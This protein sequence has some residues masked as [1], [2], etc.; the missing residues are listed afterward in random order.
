MKKILVVDDL[1]VD[2]MLTRMASSRH[3]PPVKVSVARDGEEAYR[4]LKEKT[5]DLLLLDIKMP[6]IDGFELLERLRADG[7]IPV[8]AIIVSGSGLRSDRDRAMELGAVDY[9][10]K[11]VDYSVFTEELLAA[12]RRYQP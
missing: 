11:A 10:Q 4:M 7:G 9:I 2:A 5:F 6:L 12:V 3:Q 8:P 1:S